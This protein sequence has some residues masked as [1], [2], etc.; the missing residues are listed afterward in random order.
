MNS[1]HRP[2]S[3]ETADYV[4]VMRRRWWIVVGFVL[5]GLIG[6]YAYTKVAAKAY[7]ATTA[8]LVQPTGA[9]Q[10]N[11]VQG[12]RTQGAVSMDTEAAI[13]TESTVTT[14]AAK[15]LKTSTP[16]SKLTSD[17]KVSVPANSQVLDIACSAPTPSGAVACSNAFATAYLQNRSALATQSITQQEKALQPKVTALQSTA[18]SLS[19]KISSLP[20]NSPRRL[21]DESTLKTDQANLHSLTGQLSNLTSLGANVVGGFITNKPALPTVPTSPRKLIALPS[22]LVIGLILGLIGAFVWDRRDK[23]IHAAADVERIFG[24]PVMLNLSPRAFSQQVSLASPRSRTGQAFTELA[25]TVAAEL[26]EGSHVLVVA[27]ASPGPA[28]SV[29]ATNL[30]ATLARTHADVV[31]ICADPGDTVAPEILGL[32]EGRGLAEVAAGSATVKEVVRGPS[33]VPGLWVITPGEDTSQALYSLQHETARRMLTQLR[34]DAS[35]VIIEAQA[36]GDGAEGFGLAQFADA[37]LITV[38]VPRTTRMEAADCVRRLRQLRTPL[39]G[40]AVSPP[41]G[42]RLSVRPVRQSQP[43]LGSGQGGVR[44]KDGELDGMPGT[45]RGQLSSSSRASAAPDG[46][47]RPGHAREGYGDPAGKVPGA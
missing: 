37:A 43:G 12:S 6:S 14:I 20:S 26:G 39:L 46:S 7:S 5:I 24:L 15:L 44:G 41:L 47:D 29:V 11:Q 9:D 22:G 17:I 3:V 18:N 16:P 33:G 30:A 28:G 36:S 27:G 42:G 38:E 40:A 31:L 19:A 1:T 32:G 10:T 8:V 2:D 25:Y 23:R 13:V 45:R 35:Y 4:G 21:A 34:G